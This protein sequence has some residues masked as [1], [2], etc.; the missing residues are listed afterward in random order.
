MTKYEI[1]SWQPVLTGCSTVPL[2]SFVAVPDVDLLKVIRENN[3]QIEIM[4]E[5]TGI[6]GYDGMTFLATVDRSAMLPNAR[7][8]FYLATG[9]YLFTLTNMTTYG[10]VCTKWL[11]FPVL[12]TGKNNAGTFTVVTGP[13][14]SYTPK[15]TTVQVDEAGDAV[16]VEFVPEKEEKKDDKQMSGGTALIFLL[17][18]AFVL[19]FA[20]SLANE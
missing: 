6:P 13:Y 12:A 16:L 15:K 4:V 1:L 8:N 2:P 14:Q 11:G 7:P 18:L 10:T 17:T 20:F 9:S 5:G 19:Y 3:N